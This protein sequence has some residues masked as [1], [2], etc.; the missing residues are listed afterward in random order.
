VRFI[1]ALMVFVSAAAAAD[2][3][4]APAK[5]GND[6]VDLTATVASGKDA[7]GKI[8]GL[9]PGMDLIVVQITVVPK[10]DAKVKISRD[11]F[12]LI[13]RRDG[14]RSQAMH[15]SQIAGSSTLVVASRGPG[16]AGGMVNQTRGP[17]WGGMPGTGDRP[18]RLGG[19]TDVAS[20]EAGETKSA[21]VDGKDKSNP[22][23]AA[24]REKE[25]PLEERSEPATG[26][27]YFIFEGRH[28]PKDL[29]LLYKRSGETLILDFE[30]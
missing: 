17:I 24:L 13:S 28:K 25:I 1:A 20:V 3:K 11:D 5:A 21:V 9:D 18:R 16:A 4:V 7:A 19:D 8:L 12:T 30:K 10:D 15:P 22:L 29:E 23:L 6:S 2:K 26:L 27:L 14:Q